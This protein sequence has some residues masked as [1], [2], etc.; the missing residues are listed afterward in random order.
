MPYLDLNGLTPGT[1]V[2]IRRSLHD[3]MWA[4]VSSVTKGEVRV[5][6][7]DGTIRRFSRTTGRL[8]GLGSGHFARSHLANITDYE[9]WVKY[10]QEK[11]LVNTQRLKTQEALA[12]LEKKVNGAITVDRLAEWEGLINK[13]LEEGM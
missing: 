2:T 7:K 12:K 4:R 11:E 6:T 10:K 9:A 1:A 8:L 13:I 3:P 5:T